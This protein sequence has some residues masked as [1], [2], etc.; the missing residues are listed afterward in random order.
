VIAPRARLARYALWQ[1]RDFALERGVPTLIVGALLL[2]LAKT[3][4]GA[5]A[6]DDAARDA[7]AALLQAFAPTAV[8]LAVNGIVAG[9]RRHQYFRLLFSK[10]VSVSRYYAQAW[11]VSA[12]GMLVCTALVLTAYAALV[13]PVWPPG[14][15][16]FV[17]LYF[18]L[19][20]GLG[21]LLSAVTR[22]DWMALGLLWA[23]AQLLRSLLP[24]DE[25]WYGAALNIVLPPLHVLSAMG[26]ALIR[27][28]AV[29]SSA[30]TW[31]T[32]YGAAALLLGLVIVR[33]RPLAS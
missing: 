9:D 33:R 10:P 26:G 14:A 27:G 19:F 22:F 25:S 31:V 32:A 17:S 13:H 12:V 30:Y 6:S 3:Q 1:A 24:A 20:G 5:R 28:D 23:L 2:V 11:L 18:L 7:L 21:L 16:L 4:A 8:L 15:L 29:P